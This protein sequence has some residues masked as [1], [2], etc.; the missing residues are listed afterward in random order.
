MFGENRSITGSVRSQRG[1][2][3][4]SYTRAVFRAAADAILPPVWYCHPL[5]GWVRI[6]GAAECTADLYVI[7]NLDFSQYIPIDA[8]R[9][10]LRLSTA[11]ALLLDQGTE[12]LLAVHPALAGQ[13]G[14]SL[15]GTG[16]FSQLSRS[17]R[18]A[19]IELLDRLEV[20]L[21]SA[22]PPFTDNPGLVR[23]IMNSLNQLTMFGYYSEWLAYGWTRL[24]PPNDRQLSGWP[25][26]WHL[27]G[28]PGPAYGY[29]GLRGYMLPPQLASAENAYA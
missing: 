9:P 22:P 3:A 8:E 29:R 15:Q 7:S 6:P 2:L 16:L 10:V 12:K 21:G 1:A 23:T 20:D 5:Y 24:L 13:S 18:L 28:Y 26:S 4:D 11:T 19:V 17:G 14:L 27:I 25:L